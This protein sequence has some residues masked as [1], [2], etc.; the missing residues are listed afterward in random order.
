MRSDE[1]TFTVNSG[2]RRVTYGVSGDVV[3]AFKHVS[4]GVECIGTTKRAVLE[5]LIDALEHAEAQPVD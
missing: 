1:Y 5:P 3:L 4:D 2:G